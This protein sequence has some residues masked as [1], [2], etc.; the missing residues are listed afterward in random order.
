MAPEPR[1][2]MRPMTINRL[3]EGVAALSME[4]ARF[5]RVTEDHLTLSE[6]VIA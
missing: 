1:R 4:R 6:M 2:Y 3:Q 5:A